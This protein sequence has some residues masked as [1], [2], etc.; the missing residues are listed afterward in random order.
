MS[1]F[2]KKKRLLGFW[3]SSPTT[4]N[5]NVRALL[6]HY[7]QSCQ[8]EVFIVHKCKEKDSFRQHIDSIYP[9]IKCVYYRSREAAYFRMRCPVYFITHG[10]GSLRKGMFKY[11]RGVKII[12]LWHGVPLK[13]MGNLSE[14]MDR[15][16]GLKKMKRDFQ[17]NS[18]YT[19]SSS[20]ER[21]CI[22]G[23]FLMDSQ[24][25]QIL[26]NPRNDFLLKPFNELP[27]DIQDIELE[28]TKI[29]NGKRVFLYAPTFRDYG[30]EF[31]IFTKD[32]I[33]EL[34]VFLDK[35]NSIMFLRAHPKDEL[36]LNRLIDNENIYSADAIKYP[37]LEPV[38]RA[39]DCLISDYSSIWVDYLLLN[40]P[41]LGF[42]FDLEKY[43]E[44]RGFLFDFTS[45][46]PDQLCSDQESFLLAMEGVVSHTYSNQK[47]LWVKNLFHKYQSAQACENVSKFI[48]DQ[49]ML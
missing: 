20:L 40:R 17:L 30:C 48:N 34:K 38:L 4:L 45:I 18:Y 10:A 26:G 7:I 47:R 25:L 15:K 23:C 1:F 43:Q 39:S 16:V 5:G 37:S 33:E 31:E 49:K 27:K 6:D 12:N 3:V 19:V 21:S 32:F 46:F 36:L 41:I 42:C 35:T 22:A 29:A 14:A 8:D 44:N 2:I 9:G 28:I 13:G 11:V 24:K